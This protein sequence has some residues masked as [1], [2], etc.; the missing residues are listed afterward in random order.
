M[1]EHGCIVAMDHDDAG[2]ILVRTREYVTQRKSQP[3]S[4]KTPTMDFHCTWRNFQIAAILDSYRTTPGVDGLNR[5]G[6]L[7]VRKPTCDACYMV[8]K[9]DSGAWHF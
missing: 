6:A 2:V 4:R 7:M 1:Q 5:C 9:I 3:T 8:P